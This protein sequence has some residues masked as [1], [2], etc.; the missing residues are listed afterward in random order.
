[1]QALGLSDFGGEVRV[2]EV[3]EPRAPLAGEVL[4]AV[5]AAGMGPWDLLVRTG[6]WDVGLRPPAALGVEGTGRVLAV[7]RGV[8]HLAPGDAVLAHQAPLPGAG[9]FWAERV[10]LEAAHA[11]P[12]PA[13]LDPVSAA[14]LP[15]GGLTARQALDALDL[16][17]GQRLLVTG[18]AGGTGALIVQLAAHAGI[19]VT[20]T[21]SARHVPR[22]RTLGARAVIDYHRRD[23]PARTAGSFDAAIVAARGTA[24]D[25]IGLVRDGGSLCSLTSDAPAGERDIRSENLYVTPSAAQLEGLARLVATGELRLQPDPVGLASAREALERIAAGTTAGTKP[26]L[27]F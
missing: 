17:P 3:P 16:Q 5:Q 15:V 4:V 9:G 26:V 23:W 25:A 11:A 19:E 7:G 22:L 14:A 18:G 27:T 10:L 13:G 1:M 21:A 12:R 24:H 6:A 20:A 2:L 8:S